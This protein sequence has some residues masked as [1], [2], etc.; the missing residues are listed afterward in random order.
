MFKNFIAMQLLAL[1]IVPLCVVQAKDCPPVDYLTQNID[2]LI[3][4]GVLVFEGKSYVINPQLSGT[5]KLESQ[6]KNID[7]LR[8]IFPEK[9]DANIWIERID[10]DNGC[11]YAIAR[12]TVSS[13][14]M[15][16]PT[17]V[18]GGFIDLEEA[19]GAIPHPREE[20]NKGVSFQPIHR[21]AN[22]T[23]SPQYQPKSLRSFLESGN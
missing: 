5:V 16:A 9:N 8:M 22:F 2:H 21:K 20:V 23:V 3:K 14:L 15:G 13:R 18:I 7:D 6:I 10:T 1:S 4:E 19:S 12:C 11:R 17:N